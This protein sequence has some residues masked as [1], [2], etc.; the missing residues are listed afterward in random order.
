MDEPKPTQ[1]TLESGPA[2]EPAPTSPAPPQ[3]TVRHSLDRSLVRGIAWTG[4]VKWFSQ[5]LSWVSTIVVVRLLVPADYGLIGMATTYLS[6]V[7]LINELGLGAAI[8]TQ[9]DLSEDQIRQINSVC[10]LLGLTG[11]VVSVA[12]A[13][14]LSVFFRAP[15]LRGVITVMSLA[16]VISGFQTAPAALLQREL[17][18]KFLAVT[19]GLQSILQA[20]ATVFLAIFG[21]GYWSIVLGGLLGTAFLTI[22]IVSERWLW[23]AV[24]RLRS[25]G[26]ALTFSWQILI[27]R[28][29]W[30]V[31]V[32][33]DY[34][35]AGRMLGQSALGVYSVAST[36]ALLPAEKITGLVSRVSF[37]LFSAVQHDQPGLRRY[38]L[39]LTEGLALAAFPLAFGLA[40]VT[41]EFVF[42]V[43]GAKWADAILPLR[44]L[45][46]LTTLR[47]IY[48]V[49]PQALTVIGGARFI[50]WV[51]VST[52]V[53]APVAFYFGSWW[54]ITGMAVTWCI[55]QPSNVVPV[56]W[57]LK[58]RLDVGLGQYLRSLSPALTAS[59]AMALVVWLLKAMLP[60]A[61]PMRDRFIV[62]VFGGGS[63]YALVALTVHRD[64]LQALID[65]LRPP[66]R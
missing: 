32:R 65:L 58:R 40:L 49:V 66:R 19:E 5:I 37:P 4:A 11:F 45:A 56:Y 10:V 53:V 7:A 29:S 61:W 28:V 23:F 3:S 15:D 33:A 22:V 17:R 9:R 42:V 57:L 41:D 6:L 50:M 27:T 63:A 30:W 20:L 44:I 21:W 16:Y 55:L 13:V 54:G 25:I 52:A 36:M 1:R 47:A 60:A 14:P 8:I 35:I 34:L 46:I 26:H 48:P 18:F 64:R 59:L 38:L 12:V 43:L 39:V 31:S 24:P 2:V 51:G 62:E